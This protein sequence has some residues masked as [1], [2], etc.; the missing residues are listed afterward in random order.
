MD[1]NVLSSIAWRWVGPLLACAAVLLGNVHTAL[2]DEH[3]HLYHPQEEVVLWMN[4][5]G[6]YHNRQETYSYYTLPFCKGPVTEIAHHH[7]TLGEALQGVELEFSGVAINFLVDVHPTEIC[8]ISMDERKLAAF[9]YAVKHHYWYQMYIDD[10]PLWA[11]V[12]DH[13]RDGN[14]QDAYIYTHKRFD[15]GVN[16]NQIVDVN[17]TADNRVKIADGVDVRF[18]Y[19]VVWHNSQTD[20]VKRYEKYLDPTFFQHRIHWFSIFNSFMMVLFLVGL[21]TMIMMRTL[22]KDYARYSRDDDLEDLERDLGDEYGWKQVHGDVFRSPVYNL[23]FSMLVGTGYQVILVSLIV[24]LFSIWGN[25]YVGRGSLLTTII[26]VYAGC[27]PVSGYFGGGLYARNNGT[28]WIKQALASAMFLPLTVCGTAFFVNFIA[29]YYH[30]SRAIPFGTMMVILALWLFVILPLTLVGA[31]I[32]RNVDGTP[33]SPCRISPIPRPIPEK[34]WFM[35]PLV[36]IMMGGILP[37]GSIF[38][39]MY[40][41]FTS[42]WAYKVYYVYGFMLLVF[43]ILTVVT[44]CVTIVCTYFL[45]NAEDYRWQWTSFLAGA[46]TAIYVYMYSTYYFFFKTKMFGVFQTTF[47]FSYSFL[48]SLGLG[49]LC[50]TLGFSGS[51]LFVRRIYQNIKID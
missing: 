39:E 44:T 6:P 37:F 16:G 25:V 43:A 23:T 20:F 34:K 1:G 40:F 50:G 28:Q 42:F 48:M 30:A 51:N 38:I 10:L 29:I 35:E 31:V 2:A 24:I 12:G 41:I 18:T 4:T 22:R 3:N 9:R 8:S 17:M 46:S 26:F 13:G 49:I 32:G 45:L 14:D 21:V 36:I 7:E 11:L 15:I 19:E 47:Y 5:V 27:A 33:Q